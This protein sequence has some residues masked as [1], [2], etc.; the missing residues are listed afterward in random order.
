[1]LIDE[2]DTSLP[3]LDSGVTELMFAKYLINVA[4]SSQMNLLKSEL[5]Y[6]T[7]FRNAKLTNEGELADFAHFNPKIVCHGK[8]A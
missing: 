6:F 1:M 8:V 3:F 4:R 5:R 2:A 7:P